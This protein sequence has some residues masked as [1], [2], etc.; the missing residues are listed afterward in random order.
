MPLNTDMFLEPKL[1]ALKKSETASF[2]Y[3]KFVL[4]IPFK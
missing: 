4:T 3:P 2:I 1:I